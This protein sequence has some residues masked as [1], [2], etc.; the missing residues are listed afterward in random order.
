[1]LDNI[2]LKTELHISEIWLPKVYN[3]VEIIHQSF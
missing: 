3:V 1:M 2:A